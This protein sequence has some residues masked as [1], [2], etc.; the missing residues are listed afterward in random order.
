MTNKEVVEVL[1]E[2]ALLLDLSGESPFKSRAYTNAA[3]RIEQLNSTIADLVELGTVQDIQGVGDALEK[4]IVELVTTGVMGYHVDLR[5]QFPESL[6][7]LFKIPGLGPKRIKAVYGEL[8]I[9]SLDALEEACTGGTISKLKGFG[10]K[11]QEKIVEGISFAKQHQG[12]HL[13]NEARDQAVRLKNVLANHPATIRIE[14]AGSLRRCKEVVHDA[15]LIA[16]SSDPVALMKSFVE[17]SEVKQ[18]TNQGETKS[19]VLLQTG[20]AVD[21]RV[22]SDEEYPFALAH[23]TGSKDHNVVMRQRAKEKGLK[24]NEYGLF[25]DGGT[26]V[27]ADE[28]D[29]YG[30]LDLNYIPPELREDM[31]EFDVERLPILVELDDL[32]GMIHCHSTYSD[33]RN[34]IEEMAL[35]TRDRG[36]QY[37]TITDH[38]QSAA[39]AGGLFPERIEMQHAEIEKLNRELAPFRI[40]KG[41]ESDIRSD[42]SLDYEDEIL[43][44]FDLII[45]SVHSKLDMSE[46]EATKR[47]VTAAENPYTTILGH[48]TG[49]LLLARAGY[50]LDYEKLFDACAANAVAI[51]INA[52]CHRLDLD[53]RYVR[54]AKEKGVKLSIGPDA[55]GVSGLDNMVYGVG[56]ARKGW[57]EADDVLNTMS[58][59]VFEVWCAKSLAGKAPNDQKH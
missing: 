22:V 41:I 2:I 14:I 46:K 47:V 17:D 53:W 1:E 5:A 44:S 16:S 30:A 42:G 10:P 21:L 38:S 25:D 32:K 34:T 59:N 28:A 36:Y 37:L 58:A 7:D 4:K 8:G 3:R 29:L 15:D 54:R 18:I 45:A 40:F 31:G 26:K 49:R 52:N 43:K 11:M 55:H 23:F 33:G 35:A 50:P 9:Q 24:L 48:P 27:C 19:S 13:L 56:M 51:E 12:L 57:L 20:L 6:F 39:Y